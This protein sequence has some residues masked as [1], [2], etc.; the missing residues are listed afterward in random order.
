[1]PFPP[2][3]PVEELQA[4]ARRL[5]EDWVDMGVQISRLTERRERILRE[6]EGYERTIAQRNSAPSDA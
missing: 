4:M 3:R 6:A 1:M 5:R 2:Q